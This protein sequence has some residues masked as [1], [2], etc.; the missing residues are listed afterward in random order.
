MRLALVDVAELG[1]PDL[2]PGVRIHRDGVIVERVVVDLPVAIRRA[3]V[4]H[5]AARDTLRAARRAW[6]YKSISSAR[7][8]W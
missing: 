1:V 2:F 6:A 5:I 3:A 7:P 4:H 8:A